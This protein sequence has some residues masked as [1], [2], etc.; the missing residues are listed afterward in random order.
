MTT[1]KTIPDLSPF[2]G[3]QTWFAKPFT[4]VDLKGEVWNVATDRSHLVAV[5]GRGRY[6]RWSGDM[7]QLNVMLSFIQS[8]P[9]EPRIAYTDE[10]L[11]WASDNDCGK[12]L[13]VTLDTKRLKDLLSLVPSSEVEVWDA[14]SIVRQD[15]CLGISSGADFKLFLMGYVAEGP[16]SVLDSSLLRDPSDEEM[17]GFDLAMSLTDDD[18]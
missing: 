5:R 13:G 17:S 8:T 4:V 16:V 15:P 7:G 2:A 3:P 9:V 1:T 6:S 14:K 18:D 11:D 10:L 12:V